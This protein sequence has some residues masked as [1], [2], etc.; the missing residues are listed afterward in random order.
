MQFLLVWLVIMVFYHMQ[1]ILLL[2]CC[3]YLIYIQQNI[4]FIKVF[5]IL[6]PLAGR[7]F[8]CQI[9]AA[10]AVDDVAATWVSICSP[11]GLLCD[12]M[13]R[14][15]GLHISANIEGDSA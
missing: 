14:C 9:L 4:Y 8:Y 5:V 11:R 13:K 12:N 3:Q 15:R 6:V 7:H 2:R 1:S 10:L